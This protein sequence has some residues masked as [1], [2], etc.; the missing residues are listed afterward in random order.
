[1]QTWPE[2]AKAL[3]TH[4]AAALARSASASM[5]VAELLPSSR[6]T[7][8]IPAFLMISPPTATE[9]VKVILRQSGW[10]T[11]VSPTVAPEPM[12]T[13]KTP[14]GK[15]AS[16]RTSA[17]RMADTGVLDAGFNT[18]VLPAAMAGATL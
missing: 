3:T 12:V 18:T 17:R 7:F 8:F 16:S 10:V 6:V 1:M 13:L 11:M 2:L 14:G 15:P 5:M 9:P 4:L